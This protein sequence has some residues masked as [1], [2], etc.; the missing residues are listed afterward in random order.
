MCR[1]ASQ[2]YDPLERGLTF[3]QKKNSS[4]IHPQR[5]V[6]AVAPQSQKEEESTAAHI[7]QQRILAPHVAFCYPPILHKDPHHR[8]KKGATPPKTLQPTFRHVIR[9][10]RPLKFVAYFFSAALHLLASS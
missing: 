8:I 6:R 5:K 3:A 1:F 9:N 10:Q 4:L 7:E 2:F